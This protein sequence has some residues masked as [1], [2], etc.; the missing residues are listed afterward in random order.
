MGTEAY[1]KNEELVA[2]KEDIAK[3]NFGI[4]TKSFLIM[5]AVAVLGVVAALTLLPAIAPAMFAGNALMTGYIGAMAG[6]LLGGHVASLAT[7]KD[8]ERLKI[9]EEYVKNYTQGKTHWGKGY[10]EEVAEHGYSMM[11]PTSGLSPQATSK[12]VANER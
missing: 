12:D 11:G 3:R 2:M 6:G 5:G 4:T 8:K 10:R 1:N 9:D 7:L